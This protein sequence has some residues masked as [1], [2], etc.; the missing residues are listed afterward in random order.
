M[1]QQERRLLD[2]AYEG[3]LRIDKDGLIW[4]CKKKHKGWSGYRPCTPRL[5]GHE[6]H[7]YIRIGI[8]DADGSTLKAF[9][10]RLVFMYFYGDIPDELQINHKDGNGHNNDLEN[11]ELMTPSQQMLHAVQVLGRKVGNRTRG[12][13][14]RGGERKIPVRGVELIKKSK[15]PAKELAQYYGVTTTR[16]YQIR[17]GE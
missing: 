3:I 4:K 9:V 11:L 7:G 13:S 10:H 8:R 16:I 5:Q 15:A 17:G 2:L 12:E 1:T 14:R 6:N